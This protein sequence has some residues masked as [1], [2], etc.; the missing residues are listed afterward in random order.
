M[1]L[2]LSAR[3]A[4]RGGPRGVVAPAARRC[5]VAAPPSSHARAAAAPHRALSSPPGPPPGGDWELP[6][7]QVRFN[8]L[9]VDLAA[10]PPGATPPPDVFGGALG[11]LLERARR[12]GRGS[13]WLRLGMAQGALM[14]PAAEAGF[15]F[16]HAEGAVAMLHAWLPATPCPV[17]PFATHVVGVAGVVLDDA[18]R[19][20]V[21][22]DRGKANAWKFPGGLANLGE[23]FGETAVRETRE[24]TGVEAA[25]VSLL[26]L[27]HQHGMAWGRSD[28][29][30]LCRLRPLTTDIRIDPREIADAAW[31]DAA[32]YIAGTSHPLNR[33]V[34]AAAV[35][36]AARERA[37]AAPGG[38]GAPAP[39]LRQSRPCVLEESVFIP[40]TG[41]TVRCYRADAG[42]PIVAPPGGGA[43]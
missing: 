21:V 28:L 30:L 34:A 36:D 16:H 11:R 29:Y 1:R 19:L 24:E 38:G 8:G 4:A 2:L 32:E 39:S 33:W 14:A 9:E 17:P 22:K 23:E 20:L 27:R 6:A 15:E 7:K 13:V 26:A 12:D 41:K 43:A 25:F 10:L 18:G 3:Q 35:E 5:A 42:G 37:A 31:M 40:V